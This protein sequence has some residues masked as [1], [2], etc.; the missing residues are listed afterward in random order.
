M[1]PIK[2]NDKNRKK[3]LVQKLATAGGFG[4]RE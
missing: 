2:I 4:S 1:M 3:E